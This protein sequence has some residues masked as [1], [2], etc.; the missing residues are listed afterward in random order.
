MLIQERRRHRLS[1]WSS[2]APTTGL[3]NGTSASRRRSKI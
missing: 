2:A 3:C 1:L